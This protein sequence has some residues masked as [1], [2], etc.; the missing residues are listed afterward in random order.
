M[1]K[2][3]ILFGCSPFSRVLR[4]DLELDAGIPV[5]AY[6]MT[7][8]YVKET[9]FDGLPVYSLETL[10]E[11]FGRDNF[12]VLNTVGYRGMN[13]GREKIFYLCEELGYEIASFIHPGA[14]VNTDAIGKG[15]IITE[16]SKVDRFSK[17]GMGNIMLAAHLSHDSIIGNFN[18]LTDTSTGGLVKIGNNCFIG[19]NSYLSDSISVGNYCLI[20]AGVTLTKSV[21][22]NTL[23][24]AP[25]VRTTVGKPEDIGNLF[26]LE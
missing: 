11:V 2:K 8:D 15:C 1:G 18:Y 10:D 6:S 26:H 13:V 16:G 12:E 5:A 23:V 20:G 19:Q 4:Y 7:E 3:M 22:D 25:R 21:G 17:I 9:T 14:K 24:T